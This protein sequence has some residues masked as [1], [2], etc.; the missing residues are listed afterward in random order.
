M[1]CWPDP[2]VETENLIGK[3]I[4]FETNCQVLRPIPAT[5]YTF[6]REHL[7]SDTHWMT[8]TDITILNVMQ[9]LL[10]FLSQRDGNLGFLFL[11][12]GLHLHISLLSDSLLL[13][14]SL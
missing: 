5:H 9:I 12:V 6:Y 8:K 7:S 10:P 11:T 4:D 14:S 1:L 3:H 13:R 2:A